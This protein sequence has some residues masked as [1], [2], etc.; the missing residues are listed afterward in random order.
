MAIF[1]DKLVLF[2]NKPGENKW[3][4]PGGFAEPPS[5]SYEDDAIRESLEETSLH[6][7]NPQYIGSFRI[8]DWRYRG[9]VDSIK[10]IFFALETCDKKEVAVARDDVHKCG[11]FDP[12]KMTADDVEEEHI[13]L[14]LALQKYINN[15]KK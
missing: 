4:F 12:N 9:E 1:C 3:R 7:Q 13:P 15:N 14:L 6:C 11:W 8:D 2:V 10:T 5:P